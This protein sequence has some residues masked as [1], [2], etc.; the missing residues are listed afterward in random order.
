MDIVFKEL[1]TSIATKIATPATGSKSKL[2][3]YLG[4]SHNNVI[5]IVKAYECMCNG[6]YL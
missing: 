6:F 5:E 1:H 4:I 3:G 2:N